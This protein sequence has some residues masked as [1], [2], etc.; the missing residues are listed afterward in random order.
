M[1]IRSLPTMLDIMRLSSFV[2]FPTFP[3]SWK[4]GL[5]FGELNRSS[6][7]PI[8][9]QSFRMQ[10][11]ILSIQPICNQFVKYGARHSDKAVLT[12][13]CLIGSP[14]SNTL[15]QADFC[16]STT[17]F[18]AFFICRWVSEEHSEKSRL[19]LLHSHPI[20]LFLYFFF[21]TCS[22]FMKRWMG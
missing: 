3:P 16:R 4:Y 10:R 6:Y 7:T 2:T 15:M 11:A 1:H 12:A 9:F 20:N 21:L 14:L 18:Y 19:C 22:F 13:K 17:L 5:L 8:Y